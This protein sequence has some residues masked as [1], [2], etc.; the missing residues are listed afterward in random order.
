MKVWIVNWGCNRDSWYKLE[1][2]KIRD[3]VIT[4]EFSFPWIKLDKWKDAG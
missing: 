1:F 2:R 4:F 3:N